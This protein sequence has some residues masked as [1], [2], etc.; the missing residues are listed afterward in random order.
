MIE[1]SIKFFVRYPILAILCVI[2]LFIAGIVA[3]R[4]LT[5]DLLPPFDFPVIN[6]IVDYPGASPEETEILVAE[7]I[8]RAL[9]EI[10]NIR[11]VRSISVTGLTR[12][13][14][15]FDWGTD[16]N[17]ARQQVIGKVAEIRGKLPKEAGP[18]V[19]ETMESSIAEILGFTVE[20]NE[21][22]DDSRNFVQYKIVNR[23]RG[24]P[25]ISK[26]ILMGRHRIFR[27]TIDPLKLTEYK[28]TIQD[29]K[30]ALKNQNL[31]DSGGWIS[32]GYQE[33][34]VSILGRVRDIEDLKH[35]FIDV[36]AGVPIYLKDVAAVSYTYKADEEERSIV[37]SDGKDAVAFFIQKHPQA[38]TIKI[39][40]RVYQT[41]EEIKERLPQ[42]V[43]IRNFYDQSQ[44]VRES[45]RTLRF[46]I[47]VGVFLAVFSLFFFLGHLRNTL[48][49]AL[50]VPLSVI[51]TFIL[52]R[53]FKIGLNMM[54]LGGLAVG[55]GMLVDC[56][57]VVVESIF[58]HARGE[59]NLFMASRAGA[60]EVFIPCMTGT[61]TTIAVFLPLL[62]LPGLTGKLFAPWSLIVCFSLLISLILAF[63]LIPTLSVKMLVI[64]RK[65]GKRGRFQDSLTTRYKQLL[66]FSLRHKGSI[67]I[68]TALAFCL[69]L[70]LFAFM[71]KDFLPRFEEGSILVEY[72][73]PPEVSLKKSNQ[74]AR[75]L[76]RMLLELPEIEM[77]FR[78]TGHP[79]GT[80]QLEDINVGELVV[81]LVPFKE[82]KRSTREIISELR[83]QTEEIPATIIFFTQPLTEKINESLEGISGF[84]GIKV[85]GN[86]LEML[87]KIRAEIVE[88]MESIKGICDLRSRVSLELPQLCI[89]IDREKVSRFN[90]PVSEV[91]DTVKVA[92]KGE[93]VTTVRRNQREIDIFMHYEEDFGKDVDGLRELILY[94][95]T[96]AQVPLKT[97]AD[98]SIKA[99]ASRIERENLHRLAVI[100][101]DIKGESLGK[102]MSEIRK[103]LKGLSLPEAFSIEYSGRYKEQRDASFNLIMIMLF[104]FTLVF[105]ILYLQFKK[106]THSLL[107]LLAIPLS[108]I[109]AFLA[110]WITKQ[111][112]NASS[113]IGLVVLLGIVVNDAI[114]LIDCINRLRKEGLVKEEAIVK[115]GQVRLRPIVMTTVTTLFGLLPLAIEFGPGTEILRPLAIAIMGGLIASTFFTLIVIPIIYNETSC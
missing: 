96:G 62:L 75:R 21:T 110:L 77:V 91:I 68:I 22:I 23:L 102:V 103:K 12:I 93:A 17:F 73:M 7:P 37:T 51:G 42:G 94:S 69:S 14:A 45:I 66:K 72:V 52:M 98:I 44:L 41:L 113:A 65:I 43:K 9:S 58:R 89:K 114:L 50:V 53:F 55:I 60:R 35:L 3:Y 80:E 107:A 71:R 33:Y 40:N 38:D 6:V 79:V 61:F 70:F 49:I 99:G 88:K 10:L 8:E 101:S 81:K 84:L 85:Y 87:E 108:M 83:S 104:A 16:V 90:L 74:M 48:T 47:L 86:N 1:R 63:T 25:G 54:S 11:R 82:R 109:G 29:I 95:L 105:M 46:S 30:T 56:A 57:I 31:S 24:I 67:F 34:P 18:P 39:A 111:N 26:I 100:E 112:L 97:V 4:G 27:V 13:S 20:T 32:R 59:E 92:V 15:E 5:T 28:L 36:R 19:L 64:P 78:R 76:E 2:I 106:L 115:A